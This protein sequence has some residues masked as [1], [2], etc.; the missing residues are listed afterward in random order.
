MSKTPA[1]ATLARTLESVVSQLGL[2][3]PEPAMPPESIAMLRRRRGSVSGS[4]LA[5]V[6]LVRIDGVLRWT[7]QRPPRAVGQ[8]RASRVSAPVGGDEV[9]SFGFQEVPP[10]KLVDQLEKLDRKLTPGQGLKRWKAGALS[11][12]TT[13]DKTPRALLF[14]H[15]TFSKSDAL[16]TELQTCDEGRAFLAAAEARYNQVLAFDHPTLSVSPILNALDLERAL[17][18]FAGELD[19][20]CHSRGGLVAAWWLCLVARNVRRVVFVASPLEGTSLAAPARL[21]HTLD[22]LAN[23]ADAT[24]KAAQVVGAFVPPAAPLLGV[25]AGLMQVLGGGLSLAANS[26]LLDAGVAV[27]AGLASQSRVSNNQELLR[28]HEVRWA[29]SPEFFAVRSNFEPGNPDDAWWQFWKKLRRPIVTLADMAA[30]SVF[31]GPNDLVVDGSSMTRLLGKE[32]A[33]RRVHDFG[34]NDRVHH[35]NYFAQPETATFM[36]KTL[37]QA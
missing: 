4:A 31:D 14:I 17:G 30:D 3:E 22:T 33:I 12:I 32:F 1:D 6:S 15:G 20:I 21:K 10:N 19:V 2:Q 27:V 18:G 9:F 35:T 24:E 16:F 23:I 28:L 7:Y 34:T 26:P 36:T 13:A 8:R 11:P 37:L 29:S 25:A 5:T